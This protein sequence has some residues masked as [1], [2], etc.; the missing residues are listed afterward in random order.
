MKS[1]I[2]LAMAML[3][4]AVSLGGT[5]GRA[6]QNMVGPPELIDAAKKE[7]TL[8]FYTAN[9]L[10]VEEEVIKAFNKRFPTIQVEMIRPPGRQLITRVKNRAPARQLAPHL[11]HPS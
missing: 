6:Q 9:F 2:A 3:G 11:L 4:L 10:E 7:G 5:P 8:T 1:S